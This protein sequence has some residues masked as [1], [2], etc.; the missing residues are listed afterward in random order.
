MKKGERFLY[1]DQHICQIVLSKLLI[2]Q[3]YYFW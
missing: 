1:N 2:N 3:K